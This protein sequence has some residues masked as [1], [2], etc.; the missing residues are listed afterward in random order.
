MNYEEEVMALIIAAGE[1]RSCAMEALQHAKKGDF[2]TAEASLEASRAA[3]N[4]AHEVQT[5]LIGMDE[6]EGKL[7]ITLVMVHAQDHLMTGM[8]CREL[9]EELI[10]IHKKL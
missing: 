6:G 5:R 8:L 1:G 4:N 3:F 7:K 2:A 10:E 9:V